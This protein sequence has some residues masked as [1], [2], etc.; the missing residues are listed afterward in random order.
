MANYS[1]P[2][3]KYKINNY[4]NY[5]LIIFLLFVYY[6]NIIFKFYIKPQNKSCSQKLKNITKES[7]QK[8]RIIQNCH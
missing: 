4:K 1:L 8:N 5:R 2:N 7:L 3:Y 6:N